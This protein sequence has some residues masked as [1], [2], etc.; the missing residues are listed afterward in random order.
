M[1]ER[2]LQH[3]SRINTGDEG[4]LKRSVGSNIFENLNDGLVSKSV[5]PRAAAFA[6]RVDTRKVRDIFLHDG[7]VGAPHRHDPRASSRFSPC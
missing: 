1:N 7:F 6:L 3:G 4:A 2:K 5:T